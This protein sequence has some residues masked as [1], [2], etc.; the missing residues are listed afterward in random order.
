[1]NTWITTKDLAKGIDLDNYPN[2]IIPINMQNNLRTKR[3][4]T[5]SKV[6]TKVVYTKQ[7]IEQY[8]ENNIRE[9]QPK[10]N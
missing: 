6:G 9:A 7:W 1:M 4:L 10:A 2:T 8:L 3:K 5:Y